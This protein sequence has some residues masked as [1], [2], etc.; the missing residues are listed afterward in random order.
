MDRINSDM[1]SLHVVSLTI[2]RQEISRG[3][4]LLSLDETILSKLR[5]FDAIKIYIYIYIFF[6]GSS[7]SSLCF[8][9][10]G[11]LLLWCI[12]LGKIKREEGKMWTGTKNRVKQTHGWIDGEWDPDTDGA[13]SHVPSYSPPSWALA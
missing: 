2:F 7:W 1:F 3:V 12:L 6:L 10:L 8:L 4:I 5:S 13:W 11:V 9:S